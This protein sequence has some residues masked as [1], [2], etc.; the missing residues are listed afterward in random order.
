MEIIF[1]HSTFFL[2]FLSFLL[3]LFLKNPVSFLGSLLN[4]PSLMLSL[5]KV[6]SGLPRWGTVFIRRVEQSLVHLNLDTFPVFPV[7]KR[8]TN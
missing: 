1:P 7:L 3:K 2:S 4:H 6:H 8:L 5:L